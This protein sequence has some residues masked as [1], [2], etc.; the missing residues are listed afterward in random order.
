MYPFHVFAKGG[1]ASKRFSADCA[2]MVFYFFVHGFDVNLE[3]VWK[4]EHFVALIALQ[5]FDLVMDRLGVEH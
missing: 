3:L 5:I 1:V 2:D 4:A